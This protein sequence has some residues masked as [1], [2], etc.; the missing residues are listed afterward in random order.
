M[1]AYPE[2]SRLVEEALQQHA[3]SQAWLAQQLG[4]HASAVNR[5]ILHHVRPDSPETVVRIANLLGLD[6]ASLLVAA[7]YGHQEGVRE[8]T[9]GA[10][11]DRASVFYGAP[12]PPAILIGRKGNIDALYQ[13]L[14]SESTTTLLTAVRGWPGVGK[15]TLAAALAHEPRVRQAFPDGILWTALGEKPSILS[16]LGDWLLALQE[17]PQ[18]YPTAQSRSSRLRSIL[19]DM[20]ML[21]IIDDVWDA[22]SAELIRVGGRHC[23]TL[24]TTREPAV[25]RDMGISDQAIYPLPVLSDS[26][27]LELLRIRVK[28]S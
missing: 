18:F 15:T 7:H 28:I 6:R 21:L 27:A 24:I 3:R 11:S 8:Y 25:A 16:A 17:N 1:N 5:W 13:L 9:D 23:R 4:I 10:P 19:H 20:R 12:P 26:E 22:A 2:F 14:T